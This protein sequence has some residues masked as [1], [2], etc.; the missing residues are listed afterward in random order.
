MKRKTKKEFPWNSLSN[1]EVRKILLSI[2]RANKHTTSIEEFQRS[3]IKLKKLNLEIAL[4]YNLGTLY[5]ARI[6]KKDSVKK[7]WYKPLNL[8]GEIG[9]CNSKNE[10]LFYCSLDSITPIELL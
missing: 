7:V 6:G 2:S 8:D 1:N 3:L 10:S 9:R 4:G 5:R